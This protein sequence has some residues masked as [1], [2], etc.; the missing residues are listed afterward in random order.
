MAVNLSVVGSGPIRC[1]GK[2]LRSSERMK[3]V[4]PT[5]YYGNGGWEKKVYGIN[6]EDEMRRE[7]DEDLS[8]YHNHR[9]GFEVT[10]TQRWGT[11]MCILGSDLKWENFFPVEILQTLKYET[12]IVERGKTGR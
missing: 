2:S 8:S 7:S 4:F 10:R 1:P 9:F 12:G 5:E 11:K 6:T 3:E